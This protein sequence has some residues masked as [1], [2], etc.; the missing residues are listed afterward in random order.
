MRQAGVIGSGTKLCV[1]SCTSVERFERRRAARLTLVLVFNTVETS[2]EEGPPF[3][4][5]NPPSGE[6]RNLLG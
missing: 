1:P 6:T 4:K 3:I 5:F 2:A